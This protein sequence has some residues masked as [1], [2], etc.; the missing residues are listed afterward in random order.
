[1]LDV[2]VSGGTVIDG[3]GAARRRAD[4]AV[5]DGRVV[6]VAPPG[7]IDEAAAQRIDAGGLIVAPGFVD[8]HTHYD[9][10]VLWDPLATPSSLHGVTTVIGGNCGF[11]LAPIDARAAEY[12]VPMLARVEGM[13]LPALEAGLDL[14]WQSFASWLARLDGAARRSTRA[15]WSGTRRSGAS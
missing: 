14:A 7:S 2:L 10:Q 11:S 6:A 15:S 3:T 5:R 9:A 12:V 8:V 13:P 1:M 4:V